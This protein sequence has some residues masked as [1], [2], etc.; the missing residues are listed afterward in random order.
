MSNKNQSLKEFNSRLIRVKKKPFAGKIAKRLSLQEKGEIIKFVL[1]ENTQRHLSRLEAGE[2]HV[3]QRK[4]QGKGR[5][6]SELP[7]SISVLRTHQDR[8]RLIVETKSKLA[9]FNKRGVKVK[10]DRYRGGYKIGKDAWDISEETPRP[11]ISFREIWEHDNA[12]TALK[13][14]KRTDSF[15][16]EIDISNKLSPE[17]FVH[18]HHAGFFYKG[19]HNEESH[20]RHLR[21]IVDKGECDLPSFL[22]R[23]HS[24][25]IKVSSYQ[26]EKMI[27]ALLQGAKELHDENIVSQDINWDNAILFDELKLKMIDLGVAYIKGK[28][29][30]ALSG[31][32][33]SFSPEMHWHFINVGKNS[34][35]KITRDMCL[36]IKIIESKYFKSLASFFNDKFK[37]KAPFVDDNADVTIP[38]KANDIWT[39]GL[40]I[41]EIELEKAIRTFS[42]NHPGYKFRKDSAEP[43]D[44]LLDYIS[45]HPLLKHMLQARREDRKGIDELIE[46]FQ[47]HSQYFNSES[48]HGMETRSKTLF[49]SP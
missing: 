26:K 3:F 43:S 19:S 44:A 33:L 14:K 35:S 45:K 29:N 49:K 39:L 1:S 24:G 47:Q 2:G 6:Y 17:N 38:D 25:K 22:F 7:R 23:A 5:Y 21:V 48:K 20:R 46:I 27:Y 32:I 13:Q 41:L 10:P 9:D 31:K 37:D 16:K 4:Q 40:V 30:N 36:D 28:Y 34:H 12:T 8:F 15:K 11:V 42:K 18:V